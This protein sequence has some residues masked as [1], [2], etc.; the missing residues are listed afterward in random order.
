MSLDKLLPKD[1]SINGMTME[2]EHPNRLELV[3]EGSHAYMAPYRESTLKVNGIRKWDQAFRVYAVIY[4]EANP[5][6]AGEIWQ[7]IHTIHTAVSNYPWDSVSFYDFMF[8]QLMHSK[9]WRSWGKT[10]SQ[11]WNLALKGDG[12]HSGA[13]AVSSGS[14]QNAGARGRTRDWKEDCCWKFNKNRCKSSS[15]KYDHRCTYCGGSGHGYY[16]CKKKGGSSS[17]SA[18]PS[19]SVSQRKDSSEGSG[20]KKSTNHSRK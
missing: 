1:K 16:N 19:T 10:Y 9:P 8:R 7:Y 4:S 5:K 6:R 12:H 2:D 15:C 14:H 3:H 17:S 20:G 11:G 13:S 18:T